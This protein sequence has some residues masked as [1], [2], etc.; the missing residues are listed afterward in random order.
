M[1]KIERV[2]VDT[3]KRKRRT[4]LEGSVR[5][6]LES[7]FVKC[8]KPNTQE[9]THIADDLCLERDVSPIQLA[10]TYC[11]LLPQP[12]MAFKFLLH[13]MV[14]KCIYGKCL[15]ACVAMV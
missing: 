2:F 14:P 12:Y 4:S 9:I 3:R 1:Y 11:L 10:I 13:D 7:Y 6:A 5:T 15:L 8:P